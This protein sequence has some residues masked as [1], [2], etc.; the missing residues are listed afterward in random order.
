MSET[1]SVTI[2]VGELKRWSRKVLEKERLHKE[3]HYYKLEVSAADTVSLFLGVI[4]SQ[5]KY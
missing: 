4:S 2:I 3:N 5:Q 1:E